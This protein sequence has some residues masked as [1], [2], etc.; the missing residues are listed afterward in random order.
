MEKPTYTYDEAYQAT[1]KYFDGD[2]L[3]ARVWVS[4]YALKDSF[5]HIYEQTPAD[6]H[7]RIAS[8]LHRIE[9]KYPNPLSYDEIYGLLDHFRYV[10]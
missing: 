9:Q 10:V 8:E 1:L 2:E 4:K 5:G 7:H 6:M 3:A